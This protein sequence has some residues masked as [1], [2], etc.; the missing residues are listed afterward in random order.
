[1]KK[2]WIAIGIGAVVMT[3]SGA[4]WASPDAGAQLNQDR[5]F[6]ERQQIERQMEQEMNRQR[7]AVVESGAQDSAQPS[8]TEVTFVLNDIAFEQSEILTEAELDAL[9]E[10][11]LNTSVTLKKLYELVD[12]INALYEQ[13]GYVVCRAGIKPQTI[14]GGV[15]TISLLE[16]K[17]GIVTTEGNDSTRESYIR[18]RLPLEE[19]KV[20]SL[21]EL[22]DEVLWF[23]GTNDVQLRVRLAAGERE[24]TTD[25]EIFAF[26]PEPIVW[27]LF[28]DNAGAESSGEWRGGLSYYNASLTGQRDQLSI[29]TL[30]S[31][32]VKSASLS[33]S[34]PIGKHGQRI[35]ASFAA[36][37]V[38]T[39]NGA[40]AP[41]NVRG[42]SSAVNLTYTVPLTVTKNHKAEA[43]FAVG[44]QDSKTS[45]ASYDWVDDAIT[46]VTGAVSFFDYGENKIFYH[47]HSYSA[48]RW[49]NIE[50]SE[51]TYSKYNLTMLYQ[52][53]NQNKRLLTMRLYGQAAFNHYLP[54]SDQFY[55]GGVYSVRGYEENFLCADSGISLSLE[56]RIP[57]TAR[58]EWIFFADSGIV[59]GHNQYQ[60]HYL[61]SV[62][63]GYHWKFA[64]TASL[65]TAVGIPLKRSY[66]G[67][68][69]D[70]V[71]LHVMANYQF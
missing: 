7:S 55:I 56:Y 36:N 25:Y 43:S 42:H 30:F 65:T 12:E 22:T 28:T 50:N 51:K 29:G 40:L 23:N 52:K 6:F 17:T 61:V 53:M 9:A 69:V 67:E 59:L 70:S 13:R 57:D 66:N 62:G 3:T 32:G 18:D 48:S 31:E 26:E 45:F 54:S 44:H 27:N 11:Y 63:G 21:Q 24:G 60:D 37:S 16:G 35:G 19:G 1:M 20:A 8:Q 47:N 15:I 5:T 10:P 71:R 39:K 38:H 49:E 58:S 33:Y 14:K 68:R 34:T 41:L 2:R 64:P 4:V 46:S